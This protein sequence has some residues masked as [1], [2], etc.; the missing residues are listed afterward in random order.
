MTKLKEL[1]RRLRSEPDNLALRVT[2][3]AALQ[4]AGKHGDA[5][6][7]YRSLAVAYRDQ[8]RVEQAIAACRSILAIAPDDVSCRVLLASLVASPAAAPGAG[9]APS[10]PTPPPLGPPPVV[11]P[12]RPLVVEVGC[13][14][15]HRPSPD[16]LTPLPAPLPHHVADPTQTS[17]RQVTITDLP[18]SVREWLL[19]VAE[20][21]GIASAAR[22]ISASLIAAG[23]AG[24]DEHPR[25]LAPDPP[26]RITLRR[27]RATTM[28][29]IADPPPDDSTRNLSAELG[30]DEPTLP[31]TGEA[32]HDD[33]QPR[34]LAARGLPPPTASPSAA[35]GP[36]AGAFFVPVPAPD[37][38]AILA[39]FRR[40]LVANG[41]VVIRRG[42]VGHG[43]IVVVRGR[44]ELRGERPGGAAISL[45]IITAGD[46]IGEAGLLARAP[47]A[48]Q[49]EAAEDSELLVLAA[50]DFYPIVARF[51]ALSAEL[52]ATAVRRARAQARHG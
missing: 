18:A 12:R 35:S 50:A 25:A 5:I 39:R 11:E 27:I 31:S 48:A 28:D 19:P 34:S 46:Y 51:P 32:D 40:R 7:L 4:D 13:E 15:A 20:L 29:T 37:R 6:E 30:D 21:T 26:E 1:E 2:L 9:D 52:T 36:L 43:L 16:D 41:T 45:G 33:T 23:Q 44:L 8:G 49:I 17:L 3:A 14:P 38:A 47:A 22:Q 42:E 10:R 24:D